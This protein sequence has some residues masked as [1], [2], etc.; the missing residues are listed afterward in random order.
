MLILKAIWV[1]R[2]GY[3]GQHDSSNSELSLYSTLNFGQG[4]PWFQISSLFYLLIKRWLFCVSEEERRKKTSRTR[5]VNSEIFLWCL[6][7]ILP[8]FKFGLFRLTEGLI[9]WAGL[10]PLTWLV[11]LCRGL[12]TFVKRNKNQLRDYMTTGSAQLA[13]IPVS[14]CRDPG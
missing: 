4:L 5:V 10:A 13:E 14:R 7:L 1:E 3:W 12:G 2:N 9:T 6:D 8:Y 11:S